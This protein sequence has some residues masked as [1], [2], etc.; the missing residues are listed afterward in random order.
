MNHPNSTFVIDIAAINKQAR[1]KYLR[2]E[3]PKR[4]LSEWFGLFT[5]WVICLVFVA[6]Y[7]QSAQHTSFVLDQ[8]A[9]GVG[10]AAPIG[11]A[12]GLIFLPFRH[13]HLSQPP[14]RPQLS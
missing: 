6:F 9:P 1:E 10:W 5:P 12:A 13:R 4:N 3:A 14:P 2:D 11:V 7:A 8:L